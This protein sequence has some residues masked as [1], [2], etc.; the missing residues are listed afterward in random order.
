MATQELRIGALVENPLKLEWGPGKVALIRNGNAYVFFRDVPDRPA[1]RFK[2]DALRLAAS[3][4][5][6][7]LDNLPPFVEEGGNIV[8]PH[9]RVTLDLARQKFLSLYPKGFYD[10]AYLGTKSSGERHY[11]MAAHELFMATL[12]NGEAQRLLT[13]GDIA[14]LVVRASRVIGS[15]NLL[16]MV[17]NTALRGG[18]A[19]DR[20]AKRFFSTLLDFISGV[21]DQAKFE[22]YAAAVAALPAKGQTSTDKW[23]IATILPFLAA[24]DTYMFLKPTITQAAAARL[25]FDLKY[26]SHPNWRTYDALLRMTQLY[27]DQLKDLAPRDFLDIQ[28]FFWVTGEQFD[29]VAAARKKKR[30]E[31]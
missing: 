19:D 2:P 17:E 18:L 8:L 16:H 13:N 12:G 28:S 10:D 31:Q 29:D 24:P 4:H 30:G 25:G 3:Q 22:S 7:I 1:K 27:M 6:S 15:L 11:K 26:D 20:A 5:D 23:T 9:E 21:P 14:E